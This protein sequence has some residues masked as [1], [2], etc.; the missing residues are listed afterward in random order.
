MDTATCKVFNLGNVRGYITYYAPLGK[1]LILDLIVDEGVSKR[2]AYDKIKALYEC[3]VEEY[4]TNN[5]YFLSNV[6]SIIKHYGEPDVKIDG[7]QYYKL[8]QSKKV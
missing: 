2:E 6:S 3:V 7:V 4:L 8:K 5:I 1:Y